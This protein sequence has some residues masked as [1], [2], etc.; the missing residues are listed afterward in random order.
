M[1]SKADERR[2][3]MLSTE[4]VHAYWLKRASEDLGNLTKQIGWRAVDNI[5]F[6][7]GDECYACGS[8]KHLNKCHVVPNSCGGSSS[9]PANLFLMCSSC[10]QD[11]PDTVYPDMFWNFVRN[12]EPFVNSAI[13]A[14]YKLI[15]D[16]KAEATPDEL[17]IF[18]KF[19]SLSRQD[20]FDLYSGIDYMESSTTLNNQTTIA[21]TISLL[22]KHIM[23]DDWAT[24]PKASV[25]DIESVAS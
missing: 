7:K 15:S 22:W 14:I 12:R 5:V 18:D 23:M 19:S 24:R 2:K 11:N 13:S 21:T 9:D 3:G 6:G 20:V 8:P 10:H 25:P 16:L 4:R 17:K 1:A